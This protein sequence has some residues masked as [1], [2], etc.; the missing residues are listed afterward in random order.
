MD[1]ALNRLLYK[2][3]GT[4]V[5]DKKS[6][7]RPLVSK[8]LHRLHRIARKFG[9]VQHIPVFRNWSNRALRIWV[10]LSA[11]ARNMS[12][13]VDEI[14]RVEATWNNPCG[15]LFSDNRFPGIFEAKGV[16]QK[17]VF[18]LWHHSVSVSFCPTNEILDQPM[19]TTSKIRWLPVRRRIYVQNSLLCYRG[20]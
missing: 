12:R 1:V 11:F 7:C 19:P 4:L 18:W 13:N 3:V 5:C 10:C 2:A 20:V 15:F 9:S 8:N 6:L 14:D 16:G 17:V